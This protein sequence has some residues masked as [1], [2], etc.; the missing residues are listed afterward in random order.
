MKK[1]LTEL[2]NDL[3]ES[4]PS[5]K[6]DAFQCIKAISD[7]LDKLDKIIDAI[8]GTPHSSSD[9]EEAPDLN[10]L[11]FDAIKGFTPITGHPYEA[12]LRAEMW[13]A[14]YTHRHQ[15]Q[16]GKRSKQL[17]SHFMNWIDHQEIPYVDGSFVRYNPV[18]QCED[19]LSIEQLF[20]QFSGSDYAS[21]QSGGVGKL[22][23]ILTL[24]DKLP[25][26]ANY[27]GTVDKIK[28]LCQ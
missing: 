10:Q 19:Q 23:E 5:G 24:C 17:L 2:R 1:E 12:R 11:A 14:G 27:F 28:S 13:K 8:P 6:V 7:H 3:Y 15:D 26:E 22:A 4:I 21:F 16:A 18:T 9:V 20:E 25:K